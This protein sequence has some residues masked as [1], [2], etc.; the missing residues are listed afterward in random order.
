MLGAGE[1][2]LW[3]VFTQEGVL[4]EMHQGLQGGQGMK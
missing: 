3:G 4:A 2:Q 1:C